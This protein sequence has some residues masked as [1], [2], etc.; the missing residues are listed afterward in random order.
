MK[1]ATTAGVSLSSESSPTKLPLSV[2]TETIE[3]S[4]VLDLNEKTALELLLVAEQQLPRFPQFSRQQVAILLFQDG[5]QSVYTALRALVQARDGNLW[6][7]SLSPQVGCG[8]GVW[9]CMHT[10]TCVCC[11]LRLM[12]FPWILLQVT[13]LI[14]RFTDELCENGLIEKV[15]QHLSELQ[16][17]KET[18]RL[19]D[20]PVG[21][22]RLLQQVVDMVTEQRWEGVGKG[23]AGRRVGRGGAGR[24]VGRGRAGRKLGS[25]GAGRKVGRGWGWEV[26]NLLHT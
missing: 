12:H 4:D 5:R 2:I 25:N 10:C 19:K 18:S 9:A 26:W 22:G 1:R 8:A 14:M 21:D 23:G 15:L 16:P 20:K 13:D 7:L 6:T 3:L 24:G 17:L 11:C